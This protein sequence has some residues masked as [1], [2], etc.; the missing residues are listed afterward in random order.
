MT[1]VTREFIRRLWD[2]GVPAPRIA[3]YLAL[4]TSTV[5]GRIHSMRLSK[6]KAGR[7]RNVTTQPNRT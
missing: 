2:E 7:P 3:S 5:L 6:H 1:Y 4:P